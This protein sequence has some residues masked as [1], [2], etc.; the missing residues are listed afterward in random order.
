MLLLPKKNSHLI[1]Y[2]AQGLSLMK[3][4]IHIHT[5]TERRVVRLTCSEGWFYLFV[6]VMN[7]IPKRQKQS[8]IRVYV[9]V[10]EKMRFS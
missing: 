10:R 1:N 6:G 5:F 7:E 4:Y 2:Q 3:Y 8:Y 9:S